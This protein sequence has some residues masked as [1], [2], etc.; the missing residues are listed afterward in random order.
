MN[1][2]GYVAAL[3]LFGRAYV[4]CTYLLF[5]SSIL[6]RS[7]VMFS[8]DLWMKQG[9]DVMS[10]YTHI[11]PYHWSVLQISINECNTSGVNH[12]TSRGSLHDQIRVRL[13]RIRCESSLSGWPN[14]VRLGARGRI[15]R[16]G[17]TSRP[18]RTRRRQGWFLILTSKTKG[19]GTCPYTGM[20]HGAQIEHFLLL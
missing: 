13:L 6:Q 2:I 11:C 10:F 3:P 8:V 19:T 1:P 7:A 9:R 17:Y 4:A 16:K 12:L 20:P 18:N 5:H 14:R 15:W